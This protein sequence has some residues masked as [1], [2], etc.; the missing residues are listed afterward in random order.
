MAPD[1]LDVVFSKFSSQ[2]WSSEP[3]DSFCGLFRMSVR[4]RLWSLVRPRRSVAAPHFSNRFVIMW[5]TRLRNYV[6]TFCEITSEIACNIFG[7]V[8]FRVSVRYR[9][10]NTML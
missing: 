4:Y 8:L 10:A 1:G 2:C 9:F 5:W 3:R 7:T 6:S